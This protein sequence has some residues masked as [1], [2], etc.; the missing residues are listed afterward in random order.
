MEKPKEEQ[1]VETTETGDITTVEVEQAVDEKVPEV[2]IV[3]EQV[4]FVMSHRASFHTLL[5]A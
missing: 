2:T 5:L 4:S 1:K 3:E